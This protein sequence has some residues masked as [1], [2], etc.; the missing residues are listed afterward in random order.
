MQFFIKMNYERFM[1]R[2][3]NDVNTSYLKNPTAVAVAAWSMKS[4]LIGKLEQETIWIQKIRGKP[5][6][7]TPRCFYGTVQETANGI[8]IDGKFKFQPFHRKLCSATLLLFFIVGLIQSILAHALVIKNFFYFI[9]IAIAMLWQCCFSILVVNRKAERAVVDY[10]RSL[11]NE[12]D[13][14]ATIQT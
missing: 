3:R 1:L 13:N 9:G 2:F 4:E 12:Y 6:Y 10:L 8:V 7:A 5:F 11:E 14:S